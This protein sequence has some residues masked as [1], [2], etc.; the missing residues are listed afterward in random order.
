MLESIQ[1]HPEILS[2]YQA[3][4]MQEQGGRRWPSCCFAARRDQVANT[5]RQ[6]P[7]EPLPPWSMKCATRQQLLLGK[8]AV[9]HDEIGGVYY[10]LVNVSTP[11]IA[12][13]VMMV[14]DDRDRQLVRLAPIKQ[15]V[16]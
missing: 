8:P 13:H 14:G 7:E 11:T 6:C 2:R 10:L 16:P 9:G 15:R 5:R 4:Y 12:V 3:A 1:E